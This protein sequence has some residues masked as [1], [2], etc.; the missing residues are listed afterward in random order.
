[1][2][3]RCLRGQGDYTAAIQHLAAARG[4]Y[5]ED[6]ELQIQLAFAQLGARDYAS[7]FE[8]YKARWRG[9]E[10]TP[11]KLSMPECKG[12]EIEG[13]TLLIL[14]EQGFG[15]AILFARFLPMLEEQGA[16]VKLLCEKP[17]QRLFTDIA[18]ADQLVTT[19]QD[20][21]FW[22]NMMDLAAL[23]FDAVDIVPPPV[24]LHIPDDCVA[25]AKMI[26]RPHADALKVG[27]VWSGSETYKANAF[28][29]FRHTDLLPLCDVPNVQVFSLYKGPQ[30]ADLK[31]DGSDAF[32]IDVGSTDRDFADCAAMMQQ[33]DVVIT[34]DTATAHL[35]G[36]LGVDVW[37]LLHWD[38]FWVWRHTGNTTEWYPSMRLFR[39]E[40][41]LEWGAVVANVAA[42]LVERTKG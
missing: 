30:V 16:T 38:P 18:G 9:L 34:S 13:K 23:H 33:M 25:R 8:N 5:P 35:A 31:A 40:N 24:H 26:V 3:G 10:L 37:T 32:M 42:A 1:M 17:L 15:D 11:R 19:M 39:Q 4:R 36:S 21:D 20:A 27:V 2:I 28:R 7:G 12:E 41:A 6:A 14:P 29:S 22:L